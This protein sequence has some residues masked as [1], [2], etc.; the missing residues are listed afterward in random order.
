MHFSNMPLPI[1]FLKITLQFIKTTIGYNVDWHT[2]NVNM[3]RWS[4]KNKLSPALI[5]N[6]IITINHKKIRTMEAIKIMTLIINNYM[7]VQ[8]E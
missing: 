4:T 6:V 3:V 7:Q 1:S 2:K 8:T 5:K